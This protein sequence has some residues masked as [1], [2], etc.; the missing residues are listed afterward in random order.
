MIL[1]L[2][3]MRLKDQLDKDSPLKLFEPVEFIHQF[4]LDKLQLEK[5]QE[6]MAVHITCSATRMGLADK[7]L[8]IMKN[9]VITS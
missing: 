6:P 1:T 7:T 8:D 9:V 4:I 3:G 2:C 5:R